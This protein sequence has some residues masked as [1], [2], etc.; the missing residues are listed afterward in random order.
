MIDL[1]VHCVRLNAQSP[2][3]ETL[4]GVTL[5]LT[6]TPERDSEFQQSSLG[7]TLSGFIDLRVRFVGRGAGVKLECSESAV[8]DSE[9]GY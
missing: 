8:R 3:C 4:S 7:E 2:L 6:P 1:R 5:P 9:R